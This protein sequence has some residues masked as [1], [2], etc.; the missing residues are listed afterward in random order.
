[1]E[2]S[3]RNHRGLALPDSLLT[4]FTLLE[5]ATSNWLLSRNLQGQGHSLILKTERPQA[6]QPREASTS[7]GDP[8][9]HLKLRLPFSHPRGSPGRSPINAL[10]K[11][12]PHHCDQ[13]LTGQLPPLPVLWA[14]LAFLGASCADVQ[15]TTEI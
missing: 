9:H 13:R 4:I 10:Q 2:I 14:D 5:E 6:T 11:G 12:V 15:S 7:S 1:M 8:V 3:F